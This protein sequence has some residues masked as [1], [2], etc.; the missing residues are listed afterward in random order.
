[1]LRNSF[2]EI[3]DYVCCEGTYGKKSTITG[4]DLKR[5]M[6]DK[7]TGFRRTCQKRGLRTKRRSREGAWI[8]IR[9]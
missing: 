9:S 6:I 1:M 4:C 7:Y 3:T 2:I 5:T 8:E